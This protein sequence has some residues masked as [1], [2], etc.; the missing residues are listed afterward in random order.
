MDGDGD[1]GRKKDEG[2]RR[3][4]EEKREEKKSEEKDIHLDRSSKTSSNPASFIQVSIIGTV[5]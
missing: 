3:K 5:L 1:V 4:G 2:R